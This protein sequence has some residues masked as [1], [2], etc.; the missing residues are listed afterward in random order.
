MKKDGDAISLELLPEGEDSPY[1]LDSRTAG[2]IFD[3]GGVRVLPTQSS[4]AVDYGHSLYFAKLTADGTTRLCGYGPA[5]VEIQ[6]IPAKD[7]IGIHTYSC[8]DTLEVIDVRYQKFA[9]VNQMKKVLK[10]V[11]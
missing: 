1:D 11:R 4:T 3:Q 5:D 7:R 2:R 10:K 6:G 9:P 8:T